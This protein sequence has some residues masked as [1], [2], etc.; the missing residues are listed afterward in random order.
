MY[1]IL[2]KLLQQNT[3][4]NLKNCSQPNKPLLVLAGAKMSMSP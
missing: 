1:T 2:N 4:H 3:S